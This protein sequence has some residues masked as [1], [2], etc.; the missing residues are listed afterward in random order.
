MNKTLITEIIRKKMECSQ[1]QNFK[2]CKMSMG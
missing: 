1:R 2:I